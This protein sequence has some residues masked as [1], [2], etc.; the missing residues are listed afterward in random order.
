MGKSPEEVEKG[1]KIIKSL[2]KDLCDMLKAEMS[3]IIN[4]E[5]YA[6][7]D[8]RHAAALKFLDTNGDGK[9]QL[10][11]LLRAF[12]GTGPGS[13]SFEF[14]KLL[15]VNMSDHMP[16]IQPKIQEMMG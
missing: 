5:Y 9:L 11:E 10:K 4:E 1:T 7:K 6:K 13:P 15:G 8:E 2:V 3:K 14:G 12:E 16:K